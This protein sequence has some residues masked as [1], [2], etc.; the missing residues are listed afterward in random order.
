MLLACQ[1][2]SKAFGTKEILHDVNFHINEKEKIAIVGINGSGKTT[3][4]KI[5][6]GE[7]TPDNGQ[8]IIAK[9][10]TIG[11]LSQHQDISFDNTIYGEMLATKQYILD[12]E[13]SIRKLE[14]NMKH[15]E[16]EELEKILETY[17]R[18]SSKYDRDNGY[19]YE[20]EITGVLKGLGFSPE[21]YDRHINTLSGGQKMRIALGRL[22]LTRPDLI[23]LDEPTNHLDMPSISWL[24]G[25]LASYSGSVLIVSHDRYFIDRIVTKVIEIDNKKATIYHGNYT[26]FAD[27]RAELRASMMKAYLNQQ[28]QIKHQEAVITKLKQ[29]NRE[30]SIKRAES[31]EKMLDKIDV[32]DKPTEITSEMRLTLEP[33]VESGNDVLTVSH[34]AKSFGKEALFTDLDFEIKRGE[35]V[36]LIG[37]NGTGKTTILKMINH[38]VS[39]DAGTIA[40]GSRVHIGYYDQEH[41]VLSLHKTIF[42]EISDAYP[43]L[44]NTKIRNVLAA[45]LFTGDDVFKKIEDLSGGERGRVSLAKLMLSPANFL[46]LDEPT[47]HL[48][49]QSKSILEDAIRSYT[50]TVLVVSH[51]RYFINRIATRILELKDQK[52]YS[53]IGNY[54]YYDSHKEQVYTAAAAVA[55]ELADSVPDTTAPVSSAK[56]DYK[57]QKEE[58]ARIRKKENDI[59]KTEQQIEQIEA[60]ISEIDREFEKPEIATNS[61]KLGELSK[62]REELSSKLSALYETWEDL[63]A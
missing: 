9:D 47:N 52:L 60:E 12:L 42:E 35:K 16:G 2:I 13:T 18:L 33:S 38:I 4:L 41:Q 37:G 3:L 23:I 10:T 49:I 45:F 26:Y 20:S 50:G 22:L 40:L 61:A 46:I 48:D 29:F 36:A 51:D 63:L 25:F 19:S 57:K 56:D 27:K 39:K 55:P 8:V 21:D 1:N 17:N 43:D 62:K 31:R 32:L 59:K 6:M 11:Y 24:E 15:A 14:K 58:Q 7:E 34:L 28:A 53:F 5:I 30:K 44:N 54:E